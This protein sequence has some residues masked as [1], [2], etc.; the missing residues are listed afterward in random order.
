M[1]YI[2]VKKANKT[3]QTAQIPNIRNMLSIP[4]ESIDQKKIVKEKT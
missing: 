3:V 2:S 1:L 4:I